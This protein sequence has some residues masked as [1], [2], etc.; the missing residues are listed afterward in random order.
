V[1]IRLVNAL[2]AV[3]ATVAQLSACAGA[4]TRLPQLSPGAIEA[5]Q[6][7]QRELSIQD[8]ERQQARLDSITYPLLAQ[9]TSLCPSDRGPLPGL[10]LATVHTYEKEWQAA[11]ASVLG[12]G[13]TLTVTGVVPG[14]PAARAGLRPGDRIL[15]LG[16]ISIPPGPK[17]T[18]T[19]SEAFA[20]L[21]RRDVPS[22]VDVLY[23][24]AGAQRRATVTL[25]PVCAYGTVLVNTGELNAF[26]DGERIY[27][28]STMMRF[29]SDEELRV[30]VAHELAH[31]AME[32]IEARKK[33]AL[34][35]GLL[36]A[37]ADV[38]MATQGVNTGGYY[39]SR[40]AKLG[41]ESF[42]QDFEREADY[43]GL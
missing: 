40:Y 23:S 9:S 7:K 5:E 22:Q 26:A 24:R 43:V 16:E 32:H 11:A 42:S 37:V 34:F 38:F 39:S 31:N 41:S 12:L 4:T 30:V 35:G 19:F 2:V 20:A 21:G 28:T 36:G 13:D 1:T 29:A 6:E 25:A 18:T 33:N 17:A 27:V 14:A 8:N 15:S 3:T 10:R